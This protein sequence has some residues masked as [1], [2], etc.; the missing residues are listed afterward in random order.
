MT[1]KKRPAPQACRR[2]QNDAAAKQGR[3]NPEHG[4]RCFYG[5]K[6]RPITCHKPRMIVTVASV[7]VAASAA[8]AAAIKAL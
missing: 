3:L 1:F 5:Q 6:A 2:R 8:A 4:G 7:I